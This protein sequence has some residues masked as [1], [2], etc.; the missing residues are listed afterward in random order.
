M[1]LVSTPAALRRRLGD[2]DAVTD[3][4]A[5]PPSIEYLDAGG[6][7]PAPTSA[8]PRRPRRWIPYVAGAL[9]FLVVLAVLGTLISDWAAR[10][11]EMRTLVTR[12][13][14]SEAAMGDF[15]SSVT[16]IIAKYQ[17]QGQLTDA[18]RGAL[19]A[20]LKAAAAK[21]RDAIAKAGD[22]VAAVRWLAW[23]REVSRAQEAYLAHNRAWQAYLDRA[24]ADPTEFQKKQDDI[25]STFAAAEVAVRAAEPRPAL[26]RL[27]QRIDAIFAP[28]PAVEG[29][30]TQS[31]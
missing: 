19:D 13:E 20:E 21:G 23:H 31:A 16:D 2:N 30:P 10:N 25:N 5:A 1:R 28:P 26:F 27:R 8:P 6:P 18:N 17:G 3:P 9:T 14:A 15:Q 4:N 24:A 22:G 29:G 7:I 12:I 11:Y